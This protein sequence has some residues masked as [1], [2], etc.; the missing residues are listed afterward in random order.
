MAERQHEQL[1]PAISALLPVHPQLCKVCEEQGVA[2]R[3]HARQGGVRVPDHVEE[4]A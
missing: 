1:G 4:R 3:R 2:A